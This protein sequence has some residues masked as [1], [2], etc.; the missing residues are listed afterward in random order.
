[1]TGATSTT[2]G[3]GGA[4]ARTLPLLQPTAFSRITALTKAVDIC[5]IISFPSIELL[6]FRFNR[7]TDAPESGRCSVAGKCALRVVSSISGASVTRLPC[8]WT[9]SFQPSQMQIACHS[10][11]P[12]RSRGMNKVSGGIFTPAVREVRSVRG[13][14]SRE[15]TGQQKMRGGRPN[16][17]NKWPG[18]RDKTEGT[19]SDSIAQPVGVA[20]GLLPHVLRSKL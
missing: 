14:N 9:Q 11:G 12:A 19:P 7:V 17:L 20:S 15:P 6:N 1:M 4:A 8:W 18:F 10:R 5:F 3:G 2:G 16:L 13:G